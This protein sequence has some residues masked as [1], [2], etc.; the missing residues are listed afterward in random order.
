LNIVGQAMKRKIEE[1]KHNEKVIVKE[2]GREVQ[3]IIH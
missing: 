1:E 3:G 2:T